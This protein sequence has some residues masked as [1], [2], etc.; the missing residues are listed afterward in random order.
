M[1]RN[2][3]R[4]AFSQLDLSK[5]DRDYLIPAVLGFLIAG[6]QTVDVPQRPGYVYARVRSNLNEVVQVWND[7]VSPVYDLPVLL[8]RDPNNAS[9]YKIEGRDTGRYDNW[10]TTSSYLPRHGNQ[11]SFNPENGGGGDVTWVYGRQFMP[12]ALYPSGSHGANNALL[13]Q[14]AYYYG[15]SWRYAGGTGTSDL[16]VYKPTGAWARMVL[17]AL[18]PDGN[19]KLSAGSYFAAS[20]TGQAA[21]MPYVPLPGTT[22]LPIGAARLVSGT[23]VIL[24]DNLYDL[25]PLMIA[26]YSTATGTSSSGHTIQD[27]GVDL[28]ARANLNFVGGGFVVYDGGGATNV[29]GTAGGGGGSLASLSDVTLTSPSD[30][31]MLAYSTGTS[32]WVN[33]NL[34]FSLIRLYDASALV[35]R[36]FP[37]TDAGL[38]DAFNMLGTL[39]VLWLPPGSFS[40]PVKTFPSY[41]KIIG[42]GM[43]ATILT[44]ATGAT[45]FTLDTGVVIANLQLQHNVS[46]AAETV[47]ISAAGNCLLENV[48]VYESNANTTGTAYAIS[49]ASTTKGYNCYFN[50]S[51]NATRRNP[52]YKTDRPWGMHVWE[53]PTG[54]RFATVNDS[55]RFGTTDANGVILNASG[56]FFQGPGRNHMTVS[57]ADTSNPPTLSQLTG[58]YGN[59]GA[60]GSGFFALLH[61]A[62][63]GANEYLVVSDGASYWY[64]ALTKAT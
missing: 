45:A 42:A 31:Q 3:L 49:N 27:D 61:D 8:V 11:H 20:I 13:G 33:R 2:N 14:S 19:P 12:L 15:N 52:P 58:A 22:D 38:L 50:A 28:P 1:P 23:S 6:V 30:Y 40:A 56:I 62:G 41:V 7:K 24:W 10:G 37:A 29:S 35:T 51:V 63:G 5:K 43:F 16:L 55:A 9:R 64:T 25:R 34:D 48:Y 17:I 39:D 18:D 59:P 47:A 26:G 54:G 32:K 60:V 44:V 4:Q 46:L 21:V 36:T 53:Y 57:A